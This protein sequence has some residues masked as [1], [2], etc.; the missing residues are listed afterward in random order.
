MIIRVGLRSIRVE[1]P[2]DLEAAIATAL[3]IPVR[4]LVEPDEPPMPAKVTWEQAKGFA[5]SFLHGQPRRAAIAS[6][7]FRDKLDQLKGT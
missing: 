4:A 1:H 3:P 5:G 2:G 6:T 7:L